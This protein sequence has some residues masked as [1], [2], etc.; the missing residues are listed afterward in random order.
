MSGAQANS[1]TGLGVWAAGAAGRMPA[2]ADKVPRWI[3]VVTIAAEA[4]DAGRKG[5][6]GLADR[7]RARGI[8]CE[9][10]IP[11]GWAEAA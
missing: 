10:K 7:L 11:T 1:T 8:Y 3:D 2:L 9:T 6:A 5:A 4:D